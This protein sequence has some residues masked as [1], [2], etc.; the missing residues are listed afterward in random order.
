MHDPISISLK[1]YRAKIKWMYVCMQCKDEPTWPADMLTT[2]LITCLCTTFPTETCP[3]KNRAW[4]WW[5]IFGIL[6]SLQER[7]QI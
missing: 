1:H 5:G 3:C 2:S 7:Q 4:G 6:V